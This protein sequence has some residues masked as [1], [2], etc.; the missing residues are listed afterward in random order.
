MSMARIPHTG[1]DQPAVFTPRFCIAF[2]S[3]VG[4][5]PDM[6][7]RMFMYPVSFADLTTVPALDVGDMPRG[8]VPR[9]VLFIDAAR[10]ARRELSVNLVVAEG[11]KH[12]VAILSDGR[13]LFGYDGYNGSFLIGTD[14]SLVRA[15][16]R[17]E[18]RVQSLVTRQIMVAYERKT[19]VL[20]IPGEMTKAR[21]L[22]VVRNTV[23]RM[24]KDRIPTAFG[25]RLDDREEPCAMFVFAG[26]LYVY[27][28]L[29]GTLNRPIPNGNEIDILPILKAIGQRKYGSTPFEL[30]TYPAL[31]T[32][33]PGVEVA[34]AASAS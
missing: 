18:S 2:P 11:G 26:R 4:F 33:Q 7:G 5:V 8:C 23:A 13:R 1:I 15:P 34:V 22:D 16:Q 31:A 10:T 30:V 32:P 6:E 27:S 12:A 28:P 14:V 25:Y 20:D 17:L 3:P 19:R 21:A 29:S 9:A 24:A